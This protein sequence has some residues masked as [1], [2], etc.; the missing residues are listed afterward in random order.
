MGKVRRDEGRTAVGNFCTLPST[1]LVMQ[2]TG[3]KRI[4]WNVLIFFIYL[5]VFAEKTSLFFSHNKKCMLGDLQLK[6]RSWSHSIRQNFIITQPSLLYDLSLEWKLSGNCCND[7]RS[8]TKLQLWKRKG[9]ID[10]C[11]W[12]MRKIREVFFVVAVVLTQNIN[13]LKSDTRHWHAVTKIHRCPI[14]KTKAKFI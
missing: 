14:I 8:A 13:I 4:K 11:I 10:G 12:Y 7:Q 9:F 6:V 2:K 5:D 1:H 3:Q